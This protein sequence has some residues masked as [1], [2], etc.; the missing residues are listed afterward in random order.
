MRVVS[1][2]NMLL[3]GQLNDTHLAKEVVVFDRDNRRFHSVGLFSP[4]DPDAR[5]QIR[6]AVHSVAWRGVSP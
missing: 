5:Q 4:D 3:R 2:T 1:G 6:R